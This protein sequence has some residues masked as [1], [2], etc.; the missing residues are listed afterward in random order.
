MVV[1][2]AIAVPV[3]HNNSRPQDD[4]RDQQRPHLQRRLQ[5]EWCRQRSSQHPQ[6][7]SREP[8]TPAS[9][10]S[11]SGRSKA[12]RTTNAPA[13]AAVELPS[14]RCRRTA[15]HCPHRPRRG[16]HR[17]GHRERT[18]GL[19]PVQRGC[20][21]LQLG[22]VIF[23]HL[24]DSTRRALRRIPCPGRLVWGQRV[25]GR[26]HARPALRSLSSRIG[27]LTAF[28]LLYFTQGLP[29]GFCG[30]RRGLPETGRAGG[31]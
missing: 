10:L 15:R 6:G 13:V 7:R 21:A 31:R 28:F 29:I 25:P 2:A 16:R 14:R 23:H 12:P 9:V 24:R 17:G 22:R 30:G 18:R 26:S 4:M 20:A 19:R 27:R 11:R 5:E 8:P 1:R 3:S